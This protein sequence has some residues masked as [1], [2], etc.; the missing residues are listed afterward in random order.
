MTGIGMFGSRG[1]GVGKVGS[2]WV[3]AP[4]IL[5]FAAIFLQVTV[6][7]MPCDMV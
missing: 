4:M 3:P 7:A 1:L 2:R 5:P 6:V